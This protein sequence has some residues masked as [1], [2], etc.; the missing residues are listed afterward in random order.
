VTV[1][2]WRERKAATEA[3]GGAVTNVRGTAAA[4]VVGGVL[5]WG[6]LKGAG[7]WASVDEADLDVVAVVARGVS[8]GDLY[9]VYVGD[10]SVAVA[11]LS[12]GDCCGL[13]MGGGLGID[14]S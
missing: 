13:Y 10:V 7:G 5:A 11:S 3:R 14:G 9:A 12:K 1:G 4:L 8:N 6:A 2:H